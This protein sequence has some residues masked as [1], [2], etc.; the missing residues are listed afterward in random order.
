MLMP[1]CIC[2]MFI[3]NFIV[4]FKEYLVTIKAENIAGIGAS[5][6]ITFYTKEGGTLYVHVLCSIILISQHG[7][8][9]ITVS[10]I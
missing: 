8:C 3:F 5:R 10:Y 7:I 2:I 4:P 6:N 1:E 9:W